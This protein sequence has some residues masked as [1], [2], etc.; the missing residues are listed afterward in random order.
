MTRFTTT[1]AAKALLPLPAALLFALAA[2]GEA[3]DT[4]YETDTVDES[5][6]ELIVNEP[7]PNA[8]PVTI[9]ETE[10][11]PVEEGTATNEPAETAPPAE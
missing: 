7:D 8:V 1:F 9:P 11:T 4:T 2:C 5:G 3:E 10:M 6:G